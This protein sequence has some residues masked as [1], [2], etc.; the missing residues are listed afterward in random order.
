MDIQNYYSEMFIIY[1]YQRW[2][3]KACWRNRKL[4]VPGGVRGYRESRLL[5]TFNPGPHLTLGWAI[6]HHHATQPTLAN[7]CFQSGEGSESLS[8]LE[9]FG[10]GKEAG[11][12]PL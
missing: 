12:A 8:S 11:Q 5:R 3:D 4:L 7:T 1:K 10:C 9:G 2:E 6:R